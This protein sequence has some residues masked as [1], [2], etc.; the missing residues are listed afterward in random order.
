[1]SWDAIVSERDAA[2]LSLRLGTITCCS[3]CGDGF[4][5]SLDQDP[6]RFTRVFLFLALFFRVVIGRVVTV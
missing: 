1:M 5:S 4:A 3:L 2:H 6:H